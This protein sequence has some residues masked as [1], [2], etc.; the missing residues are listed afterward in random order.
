MI[1][2]KFVLYLMRWQF[3]TPVLWL[4][5]HYLLPITSEMVATIVAN[6]IGGCIFYFIDKKIFERK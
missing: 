3:S 4:A 2:H 5:L 1:N 6:L